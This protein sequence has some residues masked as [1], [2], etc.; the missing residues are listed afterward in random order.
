LLVM[1]VVGTCAARSMWSMHISESEKLD[2]ERVGRTT[3]RLVV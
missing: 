1:S 2:T 3:G